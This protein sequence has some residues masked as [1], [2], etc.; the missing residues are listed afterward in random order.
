MLLPR[1]SGMSRDECIL[2]PGIIRKTMQLTGSSGNINKQCKFFENPEVLQNLY[3]DHEKSAWHLKTVVAD[4]REL[5]EEM[6]SETL[7]KQFHNVE[8][9]YQKKINPWKLLSISEEIDEYS[10]ASSKKKCVGDEGLIV[11]ASLLDHLPNLGGLCRT[12]EIFGVNKYV[13]NSLK[14]VNDQHFQSLSVSAQ[15]WVNILEVK[16]HIKNFGFFKKVK[17]HYKVITNF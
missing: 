5:G 1:L 8:V 14:V 13:I 4:G 7:S 6:P 2:H 12:C 3:L 9:N 10:S 11:V 16:W 17:K 15:N